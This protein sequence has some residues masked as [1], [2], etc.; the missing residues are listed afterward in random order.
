MDLRLNEGGSVW[1]MLA[2]IGPI[3]GEGCYGSYVTTSGQILQ[4][5]RYQQ[6][7][8]LLGDDPID[9]VIPNYRLMTSLPSVAVLTSQFTASS[10]E[11]IA[12][13]FRGRPNSRSF[14]QPTRGLTTANQG[15]RLADGAVLVL[16]TANT[17]DQTGKVYQG[18]I[19]P[20]THIQ[21]DWSQFGTDTDPVLIAAVG[22]LT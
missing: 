19:S 1:P 6:G 21:P 3:L 16:A 14:G 17:A 11:G 15:F 8:A 18:A 5:W 2:G 20:N 13:A 4:K 10:G 22:W 7:Q 9:A 12:I